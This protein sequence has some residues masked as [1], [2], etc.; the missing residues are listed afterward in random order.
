MSDTGQCEVLVVDGAP[1]DAAAGVVSVVTA[2]GYPA[3]GPERVA[4]HTTAI[5]ERAQ[6]LA[7]DGAIWI[8]VVGGAQFAAGYLAV[9]GVELAMTHRLDGFAD[10]L[11]HRLL[12]RVGPRA[13]LL[14][15]A[16][17]VIGRSVVTVVPGDAEAARVALGE[18]VLPSLQALVSVAHRGRPIDSAPPLPPVDTFDA[19]DTLQPLPADSEDDVPVVEGEIVTDEVP[20][21]SGSLGH[22]GRQAVSIV[23]DLDP[24]ADAPA[25]PA[26]RPDV[27]W[28]RAVYEVGGEVD[29]AIREE[30]PQPVEALAP[31]LD[32]LHQA[33]DQAVLVL[34]SGIKYSLFGF[35]DLRRPSSKVLAVGWG[36]PVCEVLVLHRYPVLTGTCIVEAH[37]QLP[38][39]SADV[40]A[41]CLEVTGS[42]PRNTAGQLFAIAGDGVWIERD[43]GVVHWD[44][45]RE[46]D[47]GN[48]KQAL[49]SLV[50]H[51]SNR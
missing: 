41:T 1:D 24:H 9:D 7:H 33:G 6:E 12:A 16:C 26:E 30:L 39:R 18:L 19:G 38:G 46:R 29:R 51:W 48:I 43:R 22:L 13:M 45:R 35:P 17:G 23:P 21:P 40:E 31:V 44:G 27:S 42:A 8:I 37:G 14:S 11:R 49:A 4:A 34:P 2:A 3:S 15:G 50:L 20:P 28:Q 32:V 36:Q 5:T 25:Q 47:V 10:L